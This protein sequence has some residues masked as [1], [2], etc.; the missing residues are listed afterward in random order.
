MRSEQ[1]VDR[2][3]LD[4]LVSRREA[5][6][7]YGLSGCPFHRGLLSIRRIAEKMEFRIPGTEGYDMCFAPSSFRRPSSGQT[8]RGCLRAFCR[9]RW[10][11]PFYWIRINHV[12]RPLR[13]TGQA[14]NQ[15]RQ[16]AI[17]ASERSRTTKALLTYRSLF[18]ECARRRA[19]DRL[20]SSAWQECCRAADQ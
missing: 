16:P 7:K 5:S 13:R 12:M 1:E 2:T 6:K 10:A 11:L 9:T 15:E 18:P 14:Y 8:P 4:V 20:R 19:K 3:I 17:N